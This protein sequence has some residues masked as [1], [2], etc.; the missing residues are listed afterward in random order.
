MKTFETPEFPYEPSHHVPFRDKA[1]M[2]RMREIGRE[3]G[4]SVPSLVSVEMALIGALTIL[5]SVEPA[6]W[7]ARG[8]EKRRVKG[9]RPAGSGGCRCLLAATKSGSS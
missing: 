2:E 4:G 3:L 5:T 6:W 8:T 9:Q 7:P 1:V